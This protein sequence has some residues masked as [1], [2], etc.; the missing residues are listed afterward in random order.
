MCLF[1]G[2]GA[3]LLRINVDLTL[4]VLC[5]LQGLATALV[6]NYSMYLMMQYRYKFRT[7]LMILPNLLSVG[8]SVFAILFVVKTDLYMGRI[9]PT[10]LINAAFGLI[11]V[12]L[13]YA[14][15]HVLYN[16]EYLKYGL[17]ISMP[18]VLHGIALNILSQSDRTMI[19]WLADASQTGVYSLI[20]NF[21]M[22]ATVITT[23]LDGVWVP[24][25]T[26][27]LKNREIKSI[28]DLACLL[29][30]SPSPRDS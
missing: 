1:I 21:S 17:A 10:A 3:Y 18:L 20:Y 26:E 29:Y 6:Q 15:S 12:A 8:A 24:W 9:V 14:R 27:R 19:T 5:L 2:G 13:V 28:N 7:A 16:R 22:I 11:T 25:F 30:T 23:S 4:I